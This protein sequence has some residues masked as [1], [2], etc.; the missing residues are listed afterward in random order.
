MTNWS[1]L[2]KAIFEHLPNKNHLMV[3]ARAGSGKTTTLEEM[4]KR[5]D[6]RKEI[7]VCAFNSAIRD[8]LLKRL[9]SF[10]EVQ[11]F[12]QIGFKALQEHWGRLTI[13]RFRQR[14]APRGCVCPD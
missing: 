2:Q 8:E 3:I 6:Q 11:T 4:V 12:H 10:A 1:P 9:V 5:V 7:L 13:E 14:N